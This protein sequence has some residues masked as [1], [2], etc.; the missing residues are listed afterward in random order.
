[1]RGGSTDEQLNSANR[2]ESS[3]QDVLR[4]YTYDGKHHT[5]KQCPSE[6][7]FC[8]NRNKKVQLTAQYYDRQLSMVL[9]WMTSCWITDAQKL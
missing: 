2:E 3:R 1:M 9:W 5:L 4:C 6:A 8:R 7:L